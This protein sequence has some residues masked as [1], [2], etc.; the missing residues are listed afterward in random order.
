MRLIVDKGILHLLV[1]KPGGMFVS[2]AYSTE[3]HW[4][5]ASYH[6][7]HDEDEKENGYAVFLLPK[8]KFTEDEAAIGFAHA[9]HETTGGLTFGF[10]EI[11]NKK[12]N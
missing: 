4:S 9:I 11:G 7:G 12:N 2:H 10:S 8:S 5:L 1:P 3:H 6:C